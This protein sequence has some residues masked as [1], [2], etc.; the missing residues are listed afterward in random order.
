MTGP[1]LALPDL[2]VFC[3]TV[4]AAAGADE[5]TASAA[6]RAR[7]H[8]TT[9][10]VDSH[11]VR[12]LG[13]YVKALRG[14]RVNGAPALTFRQTRAATGM[15]DADHAHGAR[16]TYAAVGHAADLAA[17]SGVGAVGIRNTSHFGPAG[18]YSLAAAGRG[19]IG[20]VFGNSDSFVRLHGGAERFH[21]TNPISLAVPSGEERP[22]LLDMATSAIPLNRIELYASLGRRLPDG[23]A[24]DR[25][26]RDTT[27]PA[28]VE[29]LAP[30]GG[31]FGFKGAGLAGMA[32]I[33]SAVL[34]GM[35][36]DHEISPMG[37]PDFATPRG[38]GAFVVVLDPD[39]F[40]G[41]DAVRDGMI[42]YLS[43][44]RGGAT[45]PGATVMAPGDREWSEAQRRRREGVTIDP[46]TA[47]AFE[48]LA[49]RYGLDPPRAI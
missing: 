34:T 33:F 25:D 28:A 49:A 2:A 44:L 9:P 3:E 17:E 39:A 31:E 6:S 22:W 37:G 36:L 45:A 19:L 46:A 26:G 38:M 48:E 42:R 24:S 8:A 11:G 1:R 16:A 10:G 20:L 12:L 23:V 43:A 47:A 21:G 13:H 18:A 35:R 40:A 4:L 27:D 7:M 29:M 14:G 30:L 15:L 32:G 5:E 41:A